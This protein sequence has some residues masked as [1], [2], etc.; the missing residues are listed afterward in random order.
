MIAAAKRLLKLIL[1]YLDL[2]FYSDCPC[3]NVQYD[4][5]EHGVSYYRCQ[6][7]NTE[8]IEYEDTSHGG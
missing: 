5:T 7:C 1:N 4:R 3:A 2:G 6:T 8:A